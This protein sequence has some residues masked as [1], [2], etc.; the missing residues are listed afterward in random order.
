M[1]D[2]TG[3]SDVTYRLCE[4]I[5]NLLAE[6]FNADHLRIAKCDKNDQNT[7]VSFWN[8]LH[9]FICPS[10]NRALRRDCKEND[11]VTCVKLCFASC[12][13]DCLFFYCLPVNMSTGS[14]ELL[15]ALGW[16]LAKTKFLE[17]KL[18][19]HVKCTLF[20]KIYL[21]EHSMECSSSS[22]IHQNSSENVGNLS[23][24][25]NRIIWLAG[26]I[27]N[28]LKAINCMTL[29]KINLIS[30]I[31]SEIS[32]ACDI[33]C[34][35]MEVAILLKHPEKI[36]ATA[37]EIQNLNV[38]IENYFCFIEKESVFWDWM[39]IVLC[40]DKENRVI[41]SEHK[42]D[43]NKFIRLLTKEIKSDVVKE[44]SNENDKFKSML[45]SKFLFNE[46]YHKDDFLD[47]VLLEMKKLIEKLNNLNKKKTNAFQIELEHFKE[48]N[49]SVSGD[50]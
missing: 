15:L 45:V 27:E 39:N 24:L 1:S 2:V 16:L 21:P 20:K 12:D 41:P 4:V 30:K 14:R 48:N 40:E 26:R 38:I 35:S 5:S 13:Y 23:N 33:P 6:N 34:L 36:S 28:N 47:D 37:K 10:F 32:G 7:V 46:D 8:I 43:F 50:Q 31:H 18:L 22:L 19:Y 25:C 49:S 44:L 17:M 42:K 11:I 9:K 29:E 3:V